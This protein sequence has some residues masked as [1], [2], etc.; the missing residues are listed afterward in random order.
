MRGLGIGILIT[1]IILSIGNRRDKLS[2]KDI[3][4]R[5]GELGMVMKE[6]ESG[7]WN[8]DN[9]E[10]VLE[11]SLDKDKSEVAMA[12]SDQNIQDKTDNNGL[13]SPDTTVDGDS[14]QNDAQ[15]ASQEVNDII[16]PV[17]EEDDSTDILQEG[18][19]DETSGQGSSDVGN[20]TDTPEPKNEGNGNDVINRQEPVE[21]SG[22]E[23]FEN[24]NQN[25]TEDSEDI[26]S[27][28]PEL[29]QITF[30]IVRG[31]SSGKVSEL[32]LQKGLI[33]DA[34]DF[35]N[36]IISKGKAGVIRIG[37]FTLTKGASFQEIVNAIT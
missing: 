18:D 23:E 19:S 33:D 17:S 29:S 15:E 20:S 32:L 26:S 5:A 35:N 27:Q 3:I 22:L 34:E 2:D 16:S 7:D 13:N 4:A 36:Y 31:M 25:T 1:T 6:D 12:D 11:K 24:T 10:E 30:T 28:E 8:E 37:T 14:V 9:L 21:K